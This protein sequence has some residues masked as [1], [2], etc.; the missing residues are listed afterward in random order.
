[1]L[2]VFDMNLKPI[3]LDHA[4]T[5]PLDPGVLEVMKPFF[6]DKFYNPSSIYSAARECAGHVSWARD[7]VARHLNAADPKEIIFTGGG[8]ESDNLAVYGIPMANRDRGRHIITSPIEHHAI[9]HA[10]EGMEAHGFTYSL[11]PVDRHGMVDVEALKNLIREDTVLISIMFANNEVGTVQ[12][13][14]EIGAIARQRG[15][16]FHTDAV[17][18]AGSLPV[19]VQKMNIDALSMSA[20]KF[21][22]PKGVGALYLR[23]GV[24]ADSLIKGGGQEGGLRAGTHNTPGIVGLAA[25]L[26]M[27]CS[28]MKE[29]NARIFAQRER[30]VKGILD[31]ISDVGYNGHPEKRLPNNANFTFRFVESEAVLLHLNMLGIYVSSGSACSAGSDAPSHVLEAMGIPP[32]DARGSVRIT[33]GKA[34]TESEIDYVVESLVKVIG[35]LRLMSPLVQG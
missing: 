8:S 19:D 25:A 31:R 3:Y 14:E 28:G 16:F 30:L 27:A 35:N 10:V 21:Y 1:L 13:I 6:T 29:N 15:I 11:A 17:Q 18:A 33:L 2:E 32:E 23:K 12:P 4:A 7:T 24:K 22:G 26:D 34:T 9:L 5:T 20:H